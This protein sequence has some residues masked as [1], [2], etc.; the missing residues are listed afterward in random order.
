MYGETD[1]LE[2]D[3]NITSLP[4][5]ALSCFYILRSSVLLQLY[6]AAWLQNHVGT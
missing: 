5:T 3:R 1:H 4:E 2:C 6:Q